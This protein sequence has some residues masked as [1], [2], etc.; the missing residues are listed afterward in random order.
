MQCQKW[1]ENEF[2]ISAACRSDELRKTDLVILTPIL[3]LSDILKN[4]IA[5]QTHLPRPS[6][7][8]TKIF[9]VFNSEKLDLYLEISYT[10]FSRFRSLLILIL[11]G[12]FS[13]FSFLGA[14]SDERTRTPLGAHQKRI[15]FANKGE[16]G[17][18]CDLQPNYVS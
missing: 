12:A 2:G 1:S 13:P 6:L 11:F 10:Y 3:T 17:C 9:H 4:F 15:L 8:F 5:Q 18:C 7:T 16:H 14:G